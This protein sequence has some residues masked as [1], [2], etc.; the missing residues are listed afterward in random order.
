MF[1]GQESAVKLNGWQVLMEC[2]ARK[3]QT[4]P[5]VLHKSQL[6]FKNPNISFIHKVIYT[7]NVSVYLEPSPICLQNCKGY[8]I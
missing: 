4:H 2:I 3:I 6:L 1:E 5:L 7:E 8:H